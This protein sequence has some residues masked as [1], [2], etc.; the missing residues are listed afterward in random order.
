MKITNTKLKDCFVIETE[1]YKDHRGFLRVLH[2][3]E[4][5]VPEIDAEWKYVVSAKSKTGTIRGIHC[6]PYNKLVSCVAGKLF[7]VIVDLRPGS[8]TYRA[9][10]GVWLGGDSTKQIFIPKGCG[11]GF[12]A[13]E[14]CVMVYLKDECYRPNVERDWH[15]QSFGIDWPECDKYILSEKDRKAPHYP[16]R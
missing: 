14:P 12:F 4:W 6:A 9:W 8:C 13:A 10:D 16:K 11:H 5:N 2:S 3:Q 1:K 15:W 7:D